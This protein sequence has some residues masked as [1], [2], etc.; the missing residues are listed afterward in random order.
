[1]TSKNPNVEHVQVWNNVTNRRAN[2]EA[3]KKLWDDYLKQYDPK[4]MHTY[5]EN[6]VEIKVYEPR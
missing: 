1:M 4:L 3:K 6:G 2:K 5:I